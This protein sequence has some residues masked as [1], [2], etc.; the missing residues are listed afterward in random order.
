MRYLAVAMFVLVSLSPAVAQVQSRPTD[1]PL[2]TAENESWYQLREPLQFAGDV[3]YPAGATVFFNGNTMV[4]TGHYNG[5]PLYADTTVEP[6]SLVFVPI[7]RGLM[8]PY[9][10]LRQG[11]L[12]GTTGSRTPSFPVRGTPGAAP[13]T[14]VAVPPTA[15]PQ[16]NIGAIS[17]F[18]PDS[19]FSSELPIAQAAASGVAGQPTIIRPPDQP[20]ASLLR[21]ESNDGVWIRFNGEKWLAAGAAVVF[22]ESEFSRAGEYAGF[23]V[24][25]RQTVREDVIYVPTRGDLIA[26]YR[27]KP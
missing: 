9:E 13:L 25:R 5:V 15:I 8:Q 22:S 26:P 1:P 17:A 20:M 6:Y 12:A 14:A 18:T 19:G 24:Y 27:R 3:Y 10:R 2:V 11:D 16:P 23:P 7:R 4:R 21:P